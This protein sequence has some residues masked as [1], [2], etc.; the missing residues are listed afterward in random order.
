M[1]RVGKVSGNIWMSVHQNQC[2]EIIYCGTT[3][4][5]GGVTESKRPQ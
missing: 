5:P 1:F 4:I 3:T 2:N